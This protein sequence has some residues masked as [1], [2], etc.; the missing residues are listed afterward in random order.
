[1]GGSSLGVG[2]WLASPGDEPSILNRW[3]ISHVPSISSSAAN[4]S[5]VAVRSHRFLMVIQLTEYWHQYARSVGFHSSGAL[6]PLER[7]AS[8]VTA[9]R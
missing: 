5:V 6:A 3:G 1:M 8:A 4:S 7:L 2:G 9:T